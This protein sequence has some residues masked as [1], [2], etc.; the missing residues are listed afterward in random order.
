MS[1]T[2]RTCAKSKEEADDACNKTLTNDENA[3]CGQCESDKCNGAPAQYG[4]AA[5]V[6]MVIPIAAMKI[7]SL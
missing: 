7:L 4:P 2:R 1:F 5:A 3:F 6:L